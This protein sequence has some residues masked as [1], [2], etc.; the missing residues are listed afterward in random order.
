MN[1]LKQIDEKERQTERKIIKK[2]HYIPPSIDVFRIE[3]EQGIAAGSASVRPVDV[4]GNI[5]H[6]WDTDSEIDEGIDW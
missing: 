4:N 6:E 3:M 2:Q 5:S 1:R